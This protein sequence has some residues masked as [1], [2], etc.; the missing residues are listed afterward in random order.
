MSSGTVV[1]GN[2][3]TEARYEY[4]VIGDPVNEAARLTDEAKQHATRLVAGG[5]AVDRAGDEAAHWRPCGRVDLRGTG[6]TE[7]TS[8][9]TSPPYRRWRRRRRGLRGCLGGL[10]RARWPRRAP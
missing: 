5:A 8:V 6:P 1:A 2:V 10:V 7:S 3:G 9:R 4:T